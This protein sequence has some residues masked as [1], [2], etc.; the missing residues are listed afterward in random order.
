MSGEVADTRSSSNTV[1]TWTLGRPLSALTRIATI[2]SEL[3]VSDAA[4]EEDPT[5]CAR[6]RPLNHSA[7]A[8]HGRA[9]LATHDT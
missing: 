1:V 8:P 4:I 5:S 6:G 9:Q 7:P 3:D 2:A